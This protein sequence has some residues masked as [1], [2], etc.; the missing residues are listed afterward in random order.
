MTPAKIS[1]IDQY[2][3][4]FPEETRNILTKIRMIAREAAPEAQ[5]TIKYGM[6]TFTLTGNLIHFAAY[7]KHIGLYPAPSADES[8]NKEIAV[9][10]SAKSSLRFPID[11]QIPYDLIK[12]VIK[13][14]IIEIHRK[15][16]TKSGS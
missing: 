1:G 5:E 9:Y 4:G 6:P 14:R 12:K 8:L 2:I 13:S 10:R 3:A 7:K 16:K 11:E 15:S